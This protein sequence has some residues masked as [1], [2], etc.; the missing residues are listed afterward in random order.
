MPLG[1]HLAE[2]GVDVGLVVGFQ[3]H[4]VLDAGIVPPIVRGVVHAQRKVAVLLRYL[5]HDLGR[6][7]RKLLHLAE[8]L[9][10]DKPLAVI[11]VV[12]HAVGC[13][14]HQLLAPA[15]IVVGEGLQAGDA[16]E[17]LL[18]QEVVQ[19]LLGLPL[20]LELL[21]ALVEAAQELLALLGK[22]F[23]V[24]FQQGP[25]L[26]HS[27]LLVL[28]L[29]IVDDAAV[30][31]ALAEELD[32]RHPVSA[33]GGLL[34]SLHIGRFLLW[35][36]AGRHDV[37][38]G[39][40]H[41]E[42]REALLRQ[43]QDHFRLE[44]AV[45]A[46]DSCGRAV[47]GGVAAQPLSA[48]GVG[49]LGAVRG[50]V[51]RCVAVA[52]GLL[53]VLVALG[54][55]HGR[56]HVGSEVKI[57]VFGPV[58]QQ[59]LLGL[60]VPGGWLFSHGQL[61]VFV[62]ALRVHHQAVKKRF[63]ILGRDRGAQLV[64]QADGLHI[65][66]V[67][68]GVAVHRAAAVVLLRDALALAV[69]ELQ[70]RHMANH[71][72]GIAAVCRSQDV[73]CPGAI[74]SSCACHVAADIALVQLEEHVRHVQRLGHCQMHPRPSKGSLLM[75]DPLVVWEGSL[76]GRPGAKQGGVAALALHVNQCLMANAP[77]L[78]RPGA[79]FEHVPQSHAVAIGQVLLGADRG[80]DAQVVDK[81]QK[82]VVGAVAHD[83]R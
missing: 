79:A 44:R 42:L 2:D 56:P 75:H 53:D 7:R 81:M 74:L 45:P 6:F 72:A 19:G 22:S 55:R 31:V 5:L 57:L 11:L 50:H 64:L 1:L 39:A 37:Q 46:K 9:E 80:P 78:R 33:P 14:R 26:L 13:C 35:V 63:G 70:A 12:Q 48:H 61:G 34:I 41:I 25:H 38:D 32:E 83:R 47:V 69:L 68:Q 66:Q 20:P 36:E 28:L 27:L 24:L 49:E 58:L 23:A 54:D 21:L 82:L 3:F 8:G 65:L 17:A 62:V 51:A 15:D 77:I 71:R 30:I 40:A 16:V 73:T 52:V 43:C 67:V 4:G 59:C 18:A 29:D 60:G 76:I 10:E